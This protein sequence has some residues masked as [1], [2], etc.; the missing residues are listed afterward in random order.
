M[1]YL[2][3]I[4]PFLLCLLGDGL[5]SNGFQCIF[6]L[7]FLRFYCSQL[8]SQELIFLS[9]RQD[10]CKLHNTDHSVFLEKP[11]FCFLD[12]IVFPGQAQSR[13][14]SSC[15][16]YTVLPHIIVLICYPSVRT[17]DSITLCAM[18]SV[19]PIYLC[20]L[21]VYMVGLISR[22]HQIPPITYYCSVL[23]LLGAG[24]HSHSWDAVRYKPLVCLVRGNFATIT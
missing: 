19:R 3:S 5:Q 7:M 8:L 17:A 20:R 21:A 1:E 13:R 24:S 15:A 14:P 23:P 11:Q 4:R 2:E 6:S 12:D 22:H 16:L 10:F 18:P 9:Q